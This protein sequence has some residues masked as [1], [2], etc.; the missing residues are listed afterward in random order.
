M[1]NRV[2][3]SFFVSAFAML[4]MACIMIAGIFREKSARQ[5]ATSNV[6]VNPNKGLKN[7]T[8]IDSD[9]DLMNRAFD[10]AKNMWKSGFDH[11]DPF[12]YAGQ[13]TR[14]EV[15]DDVDELSISFFQGEK[16]FLGG[17]SIE[18]RVSAPQI[19]RVNE[20]ER[21]FAEEGMP[22]VKVVIKRVLES[23][24]KN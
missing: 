15:P 6:S 9:N 11:N 24:Q 17:R 13:T 14:F 10:L 4:G 20:V 3:A 21:S 12:S 19:F 1:R 16:I 8:Q 23:P 22:V 7:K 18:S 5:L 2:K